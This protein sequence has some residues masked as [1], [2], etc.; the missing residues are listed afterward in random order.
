MSKPEKLL[1]LMVAGEVTRGD[2][3]KIARM[4][5]NGVTQHNG[6]EGYT[7][8]VANFDNL[9]EH[10]RGFIVKGVLESSIEN[11]LDRSDNE[12]EDDEDVDEED[13]TRS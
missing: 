3:E 4:I 11:I 12:V 7:L 1:D 10:V 5:F 9:P 2:V 13:V 6:P 8:T